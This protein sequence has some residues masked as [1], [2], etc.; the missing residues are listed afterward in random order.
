VVDHLTSTHT[1]AVL[2]FGANLG[3]REQTI[4]DAVLELESSPGILSVSLSSL[5]E[6]VAVTEA[7]PSTDEPAY[8]NAVA[9]VDTT[10]SPRELLQTALEIE[11]QFGRIRSERWAARTLDIDIVAYGQERVNES[12]LVVPHPHA[13]HRLFVLNPWLELDPHATLVGVGPVAEIAAD[14]EAHQNRPAEVAQ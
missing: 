1:A 8:V 3:D 6:S 11:Q 13:A 9:L 4:R 10:L 2:A 12:D 7:G 5:V 14:L